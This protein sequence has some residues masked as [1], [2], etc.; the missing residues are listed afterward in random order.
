MA[1]FGRLLEFFTLTCIETL[2][3]MAH[4]RLTSHYIKNKKIFYIDKCTGLM[5]KHFL[6]QLVR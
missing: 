1:K 4:L 2:S 3:L 6:L 5:Y